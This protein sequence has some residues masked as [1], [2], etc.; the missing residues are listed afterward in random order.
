M[1]HRLSKRIPSHRTAI[2]D[3]P[4]VGG[5]RVTLRNIG[6]GGVLVEGPRSF[7]PM[8]A[9]LMLAFS[10]ENGEQQWDF[11]FEAMVVRHSLRGAALMFS[12]LE[13]DVLR[14]LHGA[15]FQV[16]ARHGARIGSPSSSSNTSPTPTIANWRSSHG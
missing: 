1:E 11:L 9:P 12:D 13:T 4:R 15:L 14:M 5:A 3:C 16:P 2:V 8:Y 10:L 6:L 7:L